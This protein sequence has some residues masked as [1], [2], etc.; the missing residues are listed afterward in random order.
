MFWK[1]NNNNNKTKTNQDSRKYVDTGKK[2]SE[3]LKNLLCLYDYGT[4]HQE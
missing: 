3:W 2:I 1:Q 4:L